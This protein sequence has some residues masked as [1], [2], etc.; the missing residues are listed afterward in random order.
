MDLDSLAVKGTQTLIEEHLKT[1]DENIPT[2]DE[3]D[4]YS[5]LASFIL[6]EFHRFRD[7]KRTSGVEDEIFDS[8]R[9]YNGE[10]SPDELAQIKAAGGSDIFMNITATKCRSAAAWI[11]DILMGKED[12]F[13]VE[14][15][16]SPSLP[17]SIVSMIDEAVERE[18]EQLGLVEQEQASP[19]GQ[20][21]PPHQVTA[22]EAQESLI[23]QNQKVRDIKDAIAQEIMAEAKHN[24]KEMQVKIQDQLA[25]GDW[26]S[27]LSE[28]IDDFTVFPAAIMKGPIVTKK[29][30]LVWVNGEAEKKKEYVFLNKRVS[31]L[32]FYPSPETDSIS[33]GAVI[34]HLRLSPSE[35]YELSTLDE[36]AGYKTD[37]IKELLE[38]T[39]TIPVGPDL[40]LDTGGIEQEK[41]EQELKGDSFQKRNIFH[42]LHFFGPVPATTLI[43]WGLTHPT[44]DEVSEH[45]V[46][47]VEAIVVGGRV[48]KCILNDDPLGR[49]P[50]YSAAWQKRPGSFWGRSLPNLM[51]DI[52]RMCNA[53]ARALANNMSLAAGPQVEIYVDRLADDG[54]IDQIYPFKI[55]QFTS[56]PTG[57]TGR[58]VT[59][60]QPTSNAG[61]LLAVYDR[62]EQKADDATGIPRYMTG[63]QDMKG[64]GQT[65]AG[66]SMLLDSATKTIKGAIRNIDE[67]L[68]KPRVEYQFYYNMLRD[69]IEGFSGDVQVVAKGSAAL[70]IKGEAQIRRNEF[71]QI[72]ANPFDM[73][74]IGKQGRA[75]ILR[76]M[77][78]DLDLT[79][80]P[81]PNR[82]TI[83]KI[84]KEEKEAQQ[85]AF[86][87][88]Q[89]KGL[90]ATQLQIEGQMAMAQGSQQ[91]KAQE[92]ELKREEAAA[93][94]QLKMQEV[95]QRQEEKIAELQLELEKLQATVQQKDMA[96]KRATAAQLETANRR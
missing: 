62:F 39:A 36:A 68:I 14:P 13:S 43:E 86:E 46:V 26:S 4:D 28:F 95:Q 67:G 56:D 38:E 83:E 60:T 57:G 79:C 51:R 71:L 40:G 31:P 17:A 41:D 93:K 12:P 5:S 47:D 18:A 81:I 10:Y 72:T 59:F 55:W 37:V 9:Y 19:D 70:T 52:Q 24:V 84:E 91:L 16:P 22:E 20:P 82:L 48:I 7:A 53:T 75:D 76:E 2:H 87:A 65:A 78:K 30:R 69:P 89:Q 33:G 63:D 6:K 32:D 44:L 64:A 74:V 85:R 61:E 34:E 96:S 94:L 42:G 27:A 23:K 1:M 25:E 58:A 35:M 3:G 54:P 80:S 50:Y 77:V 73:A 45:A 29:D 11:K 88:E 66:L 21:L 92:L 8:L 49:R 15:T 90:A